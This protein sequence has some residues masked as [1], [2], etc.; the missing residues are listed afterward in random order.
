MIPTDDLEA[1]AASTQRFLATVDAMDVTDLAA[2]SLLPGWS[3]LHVLSHVAR[4]ADGMR[5]RLLMARTGRPVAQY[6]SMA[7]RA[8]DIETGALRDPELVRQDLR[9]A[10]ER[11]AIDAESLTDADWAR[12]AGVGD[13]AGRL[14]AAGLPLVAPARGRDPSRRPRGGLHVRR[15]ARRRGRYVPRPGPR[16]VRRVRA[17]PVPRSP[18]RTSA[19]SWSVGDGTGPQIEGPSGALLTWATG[20]GTAGRPD[21]EQWHRPRLTRLGLTPQGSRTSFPVVR[22]ASRS[23]WASAASPRPYRPPIRTSSEPSTIAPKTSPA[24]QS[25][26]SRV[27]R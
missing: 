11:L 1:L 22:L 16:Q 24:R 4:N 12:D 6:P 26:S 23:R 9:A 19:K 20:R 21:V 5:N 25:S 27:A 18:R 13:L 3:R 7:L 14:P 17:R 2:P 10:C 15:H 8:A